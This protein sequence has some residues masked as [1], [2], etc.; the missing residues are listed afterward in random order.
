MKF[1]TSISSYFT[2]LINNYIA[3][4]GKNIYCFTVVKLLWSLGYLGSYGP[5]R[6]SPIP[7]G[8]GCW[9][10]VNHHILMAKRLGYWFLDN[11]RS[12]IYDTYHFNRTLLKIDAT[13]SEQYI[14]TF[15]VP[16]VCSHTG[17]KFVLHRYKWPCRL[18]LRQNL[19]VCRRFK[20]LH[21][22]WKTKD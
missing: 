11:I 3:Q 15:E 18:A 16:K 9:D 1:T 17:P 2:T 19:P 22:M 12:R 14:R 6:L 5:A 4:K 10:K 7:R 13:T 8:V 20:H 21:G